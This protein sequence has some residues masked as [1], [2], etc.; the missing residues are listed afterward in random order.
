MSLRPMNDLIV[1]LPGIMG[2]V[3]QKDGRDLWSPSLSAV[4]R[5]LQRETLVRDLTLADDDSERPSLD[6][7]VVA[8][9]LFPDAHLIPGFWKIDGYTNFIRSIAQQFEVREGDVANPHPHANLFP[10]PYDWRRDNRANARRLKAFIDTQLPQL[11]TRSPHAR[12]IL[13]AHSMGG[14]ISRYYLE[15]LGGWENCR[16]LFT[17][18]TPYKG[19]PKALD[20]LSTGFKKFGIDV[21]PALRSYTSVY[22]LLPTYNLIERGSATLS[23]SELNALARVDL[24]RAREARTEFHDAITTAAEARARS[25]HAGA[26]ITTIVAGVQQETL[27][28]AVLER[29]VLK[30]G[31]AMP[32]PLGARKFP[33]YGDGTVPFF[34]ALPQGARAADLRPVFVAESHG[35]LQNNAFIVGQIHEMLYLLQMGE[36]LDAGAFTVGGRASLSL[37]VQD[38]YP[39]EGGRFS[40]TAVDA[41]HLDLGA[42]IARL[43][44]LDGSNPP[45]EAP[46]QR[47]GDAWVYDLEHPVP[48]VYRVS[49][50]TSYSGADAPLPVHEL[51]EVLG[52]P[53]KKPRARS[54]RAVKPATA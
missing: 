45:I 31:E 35:A 25:S 18:G 19:A 29:G 41:D 44:P 38:A 15:V 42:V 40:V 34:A 8:T 30:V 11:R 23:L 13:I 16:A 20:Y 39:A 9:R 43:T 26:Y 3:L 22:Q 27:Q 51:F 36:M 24:K 47:E 50:R 6:D 17:L 33:D 2:S 14:L 1:V 12:V 54:A 10:F 7:G 53:A 32:R 46:L 5:I 28:S 52:E 4:S 37:S 49:V 48:G 21:S